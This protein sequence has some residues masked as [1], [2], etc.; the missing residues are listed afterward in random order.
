MCRGP[1]NNPVNFGG[2]PDYNPDP[3]SGLQSEYRIFLRRLV[4]GDKEESIKILYYPDYDPDPMHNH[5]AK[6][7]SVTSVTL[8]RAAEVCIVRLTV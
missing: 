2:D 1:R 7:V 6:G 5:F 8:C 4:S 3:V